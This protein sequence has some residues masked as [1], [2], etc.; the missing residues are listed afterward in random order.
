M[1]ENS[2]EKRVGHRFLAGLKAAVTLETRALSCRAVDLHRGGVLLEGNLEADRDAVAF[3][4]LSS[5]AEDLNFESRGRVTHVEQNDKSGR[6]RIGIQFESMSDAQRETLE[7]LVSRVVEGMSPAPLAHLPR[8][9]TIDEIRDALKSIPLAHRITVA[10]KALPPERKFLFHDDSN[11]VLEAMCRNP[12]LTAP[13]V[14]RVLRIPTLLPTTLDLL[15]RDPRW[16]GNEEI[17]I[18]IA[19]HPR[20]TLPVA[21]RLVRTLSLPGIRKVIRL[22][23]L[24]PT[25]KD[26]LVQSIPHKQLQGW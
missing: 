8:D 9:A 5:S 2:S 13:E 3:V 25:I 4:T 6:T 16:T 22:P 21:D 26:R 11:L 17:K 7:L 18:M 23:G 12:H 14:I 19:T 1:S 20:V 10:Q 24:N 15:S